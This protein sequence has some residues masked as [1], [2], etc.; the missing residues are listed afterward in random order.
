MKYLAL[1]LI[2]ISS[3]TA[4]ADNHADYGCVGLENDISV[5]HGM[6]HQECLDVLSKGNV[7][8]QEKYMGD[9]K[10]TII[11]NGYEFNVFKH[12]PDENADNSVGNYQYDCLYKVKLQRCTD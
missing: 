2:I 9:N 8:W 12:K 4:F 6:T 5:N 10:M 7:I 1:I 3:S 11:Y